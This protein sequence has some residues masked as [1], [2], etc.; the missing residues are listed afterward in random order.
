[1]EAREHFVRCKKPLCSVCA[2]AP[3]HGPYWYGFAWHEGKKVKFA[4]F[5]KER[6]TQ[7]EIL[8]AWERYLERLKGPKAKAKA[9]AGTKSGSKGPKAKA[10]PKAEPVDDRFVYGRMSRAVALRILGLEPGYSRSQMRAARRELSLRFHPDRAPASKRAAYDMI[11]RAV[12]AAADYL[13]RD[14]GDS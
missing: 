6:P 3:A 13:G 4:Y 11:M 9:K 5:G 12:N 1:M 8:A 2:D 7:K 14:S 10:E